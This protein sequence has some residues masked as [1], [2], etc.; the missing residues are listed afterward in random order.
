MSFLSSFV[1]FFEDSPVTPPDDD[2]VYEGVEVPFAYLNVDPAAEVLT[3]GLVIDAALDPQ[4]LEETWKTLVEQ[5]FPR[6]GAQLLGG[7]IIEYFLHSPDTFTS[8]NPSTVF[9]A[10]HYHEPYRTSARRNIDVLLNSS[11][12]EPTCCPSPS[13]RAYL[14]SEE[15]LQYAD[16]LLFRAA[17]RFRFSEKHAFNI[18][19]SVFDDLTLIGITYF[20]VVSDVG[21]IRTLLH[22]WAR[23]ISGESIA[24]IAGMDRDVRPANYIRPP[25]ELDTFLER[26]VNT[27]RGYWHQRVPPTGSF[28]ELFARIDDDS[29]GRNR[30]IMSRLWHWMCG[31]DG[32][33]RLVRVPKTFLDDRRREILENLKLNG[34]T[35]SVDHS[36]V[37]LGWWFKTTYSTRSAFDTTPISLHISVDLRPIIF[38]E[39]SAM[40]GPY[41]NQASSTI[42]IAPPIPANAFRRMSLEALALL[43]H[44]ARVDYH[45]DRNALVRELWWRVEHQTRLLY[46][47][48]PGGEA[49][50][51]TDWSA[52]R[53]AGMDFSGA[54]GM[55]SE[56]KGAGR[57]VFVVTE[58][59]E[60]EKGSGEILM[61]DENAVWMSQVKTS[62]EWEKL[63]RSG[64]FKFV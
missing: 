52:A 44:R 7:Y 57:V 18:H 34:S 40:S 55:G 28:K 48:P 21:G 59:L 62:E 13:L 5:K 38:T 36:D 53:L 58:N 2:Y 4:I 61:E 33:R 16:S 63:R 49:A 22:S 56:S 17:E 27:I 39:D 9:T 20:H 26:D 1:S 42:V 45:A 19:V 32:E 11:H 60:E 12:S 23:L 43:I 14:V 35:E 25:N 30:R 41:I 6:A 15:R 29:S 31:V 64:A 51:Q 8:D 24:A 37:L 46:R 50:L 3:T 47:C 10:K 54:R